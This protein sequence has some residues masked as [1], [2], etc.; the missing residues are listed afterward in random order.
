VS[1]RTVLEQSRTGQADLAGL[2]AKKS[3][4]GVLGS[5]R[6]VQVSERSPSGIGG[7]SV[8]TSIRLVISILVFS[9][10]SLFLLLLSVPSRVEMQLKLTR[11]ELTSGHICLAD[12]L[13]SGVK[14]QETQ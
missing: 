3:P 8:K 5:P 9:M 2:P 4:S 1:A 7:G 14:I 13:A 10:T 6:T 12:F 11:E